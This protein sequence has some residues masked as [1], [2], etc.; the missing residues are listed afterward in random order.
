MTSLDSP[1]LKLYRRYRVSLL[2]AEV[3]ARREQTFI[4]VVRIYLVAG[5]TYRADNAET[6][7]LFPLT[8]PI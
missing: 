8:G 1:V 4:H 3:R 7:T 5:H 2:R 6:L